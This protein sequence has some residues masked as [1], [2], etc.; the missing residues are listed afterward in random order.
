M[1]IYEF[2]RF[3]FHLGVFWCVFF[4]IL[5][6]VS[7]GTLTSPSVIITWWDAIWM[8]FVGAIVPFLLGLLS[9]VKKI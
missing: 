5:V 3:N 7:V 2:N 9:F 1:I 8:T 4:F 6:A